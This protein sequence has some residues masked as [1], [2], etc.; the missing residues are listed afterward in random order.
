M[1]R[2]DC[3]V[4]MLI[5]L[6]GAFALTSCDVGIEQQFSPP[7]TTAV[8]TGAQLPIGQPTGIGGPLTTPVVT[9]PTGPSITEIEG[10]LGVTYDFHWQ[11]SAVGDAP[12]EQRHTFRVTGM[13][14]PSPS[15][16]SRTVNLRMT[17]A[18][19]GAE[20]FRWGTG[21][22]RPTL[23]CGD[24]QEIWVTVESDTFMIEAVAHPGVP[25]E[26]TYFLQISVHMPY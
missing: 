4:K 15:S 21:T 6:L 9:I 7:P 3:S 26:M 5:F 23:K 20:S 2:P 19:S 24:S 8:E 25:M 13:I 18:G 12:V 22:H 16:T 14:P 11:L 10:S 17:C 1:Q